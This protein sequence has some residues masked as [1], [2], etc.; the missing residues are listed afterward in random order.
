[1]KLYG[2]RAQIWTWGISNFGPACE[3]DQLL[4]QLNLVST[5]VLS[6][7]GHELLT[8]G[9]TRKVTESEVWTPD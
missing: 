7:D 6:V 1:M 8:T 9:H 3:T 5:S 2:S 4:Q